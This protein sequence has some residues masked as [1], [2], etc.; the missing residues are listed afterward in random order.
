LH[1]ED[2]VTQMKLLDLPHY[3][4]ADRREYREIIREILLQSMW[5]ASRFCR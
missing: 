5:Y 2:F 4:T 3:T 1:Q